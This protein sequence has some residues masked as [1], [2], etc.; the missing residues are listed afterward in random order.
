VSHEGHEFGTVENLAAEFG[1]AERAGT[2]LKALQAASKLA[3]VF[4]ETNTSARYTFESPI[5][6]E[7]G[8][9]LQ[10]IGDRWYIAD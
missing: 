1:K 4:N 9:L 7:R 8:L 2:L 5:G 6:R 10:K 3:P